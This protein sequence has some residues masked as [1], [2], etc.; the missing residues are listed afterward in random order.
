MC[1][2]PLVCKNRVFARLLDQVREGGSRNR[3]TEQHGYQTGCA[4]ESPDDEE[5]TPR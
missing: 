5:V 4:R 2:T 1:R 3:E